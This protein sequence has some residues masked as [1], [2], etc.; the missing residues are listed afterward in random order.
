ML[1]SALYFLGKDFEALIYHF[2]S[3]AIPVV[4]SVKLGNGKG[5]IIKEYPDPLLGELAAS[6]WVTQPK[7]QTLAARRSLRV[8]NHNNQSAAHIFEDI[9]YGHRHYSLMHWL[10][11]NNFLPLIRSEDG[12]SSKKSEELYSSALRTIL[13]KKRN[14]GSHTEWSVIWEIILLSRLPNYD[15]VIASESK[16]NGEIIHLEEEIFQSLQKFISTYL[17]NNYL[18]YHPAM[19]WKKHV[20]SPLLNEFLNNQSSLATFQC[21]T[22]YTEK[23]FPKETRR[24]SS[25]YSVYSNLYNSFRNAPSHSAANFSLDLLLSE[26]NKE[27]GFFSRFGDLVSVVE[28]FRK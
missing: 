22:C 28:Y 21:D 8:Q 26:L 13:N 14:I 4:E 16:T 19:K 12:G 17:T 6:H 7:R 11:P 18:T 2:P 25:K 9:D 23:A 15:D 3:Q 27:K 20:P 5:N 1:S 10:F 24:K